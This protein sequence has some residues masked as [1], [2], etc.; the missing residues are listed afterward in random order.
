M[1]RL[2][3]LAGTLLCL[4]A[5][6]TALAQGTHLAWN[7][8]GA[9]GAAD[10]AFACN[11]ST[12]LHQLVSSFNAPA[13]ITHFIG[14][15]SEILVAGQAPLGPWW[16]L[17]AG[18]CRTGALSSEDPSALG[19]GDCGFETFDGS[20]NLGLANYEPNYQG[21]PNNARI[22]T[23]MARSDAG[24]PLVA[25]QEYQANVIQIR[26]TKTPA[27]RPAPAASTRSPSGRSAC[28]SP[29]PPVRTSCRVVAPPVP[30]RASTVP[31]AATWYR[32]GVSRGAR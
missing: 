4:A 22:T 7:G 31:R 24:V 13:G 25:G 20:T 1:K 14:A 32:P 16:A 12:T 5:P 10:N 17:Q 2:L 26:S 30:A 9:A 6:M 15:T 8:C 21:N 28:S 29:S 27:R 19:L 11:N 3:V 18:G 23:D